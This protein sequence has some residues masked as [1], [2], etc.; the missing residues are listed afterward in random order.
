[1]EGWQNDLAGKRVF[2]Y[3]VEEE[4]QLLQLNW[5]PHMHCGMCVTHTQKEM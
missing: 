4:K 2:H 1:M 5:G 3:M